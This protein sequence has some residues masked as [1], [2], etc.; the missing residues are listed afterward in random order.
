MVT[1]SL[2]G[3][4][5]ENEAVVTAETHK[6]KKQKKWRVRFTH[7]SSSSKLLCA[8]TYSNCTEKQILPLPLSQIS[9]IRDDY[10]FN[11]TFAHKLHNVE[12][13]QSPAHKL[14]TK[15]NKIFLNQCFIVYTWLCFLTRNLT[16]APCYHSFKWHLFVVK[17]TKNFVGF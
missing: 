5:K 14:W 9:I 3:N 17:S 15:Q 1:K 4:E 11:L 8:S 13:L 16:T 7:S 10:L 12:D 6:S 2:L